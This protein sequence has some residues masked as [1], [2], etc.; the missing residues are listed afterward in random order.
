MKSLKA[1]L[2][3][4]EKRTKEDLLKKGQCVS[5]TGLKRK[6]SCFLVHHFY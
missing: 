1:L 5:P 4:T 6:N 2:Y 3:V